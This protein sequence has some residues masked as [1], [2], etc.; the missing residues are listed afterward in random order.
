MLVFGNK[1]AFLD[2]SEDVSPA[3]DPVLGGLVEIC[4]HFLIYSH[5]V[6][7][8]FLLMD[9]YFENFGLIVP[10][11]ELDTLLRNIE[12][13]TDTLPLEN[14]LVKALREEYRSRV[15]QLFVLLYANDML[16]IALEEH[17]ASELRVAGSQ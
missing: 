14:L 8:A 7:L 17:F 2:V 3:A 1:L 5:V 9:E 16:S 4:L 12:S 10:I 6:E 13:F 11:P 15:Q